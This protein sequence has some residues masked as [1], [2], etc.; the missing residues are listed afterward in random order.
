[1][2]SHPRSGFP[3]LLLQD[4][5]N[6]PCQFLP[7]QPYRQQCPPQSSTFHDDCNLAGSLFALALLLEHRFVL[8]NSWHTHQNKCVFI[9]F[10]IVHV[11]LIGRCL[12][13]NTRNCVEQGRTHSCMTEHTTQLSP[14]FTIE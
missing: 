9:L 5:G 12:T 13:E 6:L 1:M 4:C 2:A 14:C 7:E 11:V 10:I 3:R 8:F